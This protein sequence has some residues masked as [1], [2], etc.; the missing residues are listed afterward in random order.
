VNILGDAGALFLQ[1]RLL[2]H[3][4]QLAAQAAEGNVAHDGNDAAVKTA[5]TTERNHHVCQKNGATTSEILAT[6]LL[7]SPSPLQAVT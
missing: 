6:F 2:F 5:S 7:Q 1:G 4:H 3:D